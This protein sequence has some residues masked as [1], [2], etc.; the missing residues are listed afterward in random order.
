MAHPH[1]FYSLEAIT[2]EGRP[3]WVDNYATAGKII[4]P[5]KTDNPA[6]IKAKTRRD[7]AYKIWQNSF[8]IGLRSNLFQ[9]VRILRKEWEETD[10]KMWHEDYQ[11]CT[12]RVFVQP[13]TAYDERTQQHVQYYVLSPEDCYLVNRYEAQKGV[14]TLAP[15]DYKVKEAWISADP[16]LRRMRVVPVAACHHL[17]HETTG[18]KLPNLL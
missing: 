9:A 18:G 12:F 8:G 5:G 14:P 16:K 10:T 6:W 4:L 1:F 15:R 3:R 7:R 2:D 17:R 13:H 11:D